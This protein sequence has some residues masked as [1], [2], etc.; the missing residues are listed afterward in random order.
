MGKKH[1]FVTDSTGKSHEVKVDPKHQGRQAREHRAA[2]RE[3]TVLSED[4]RIKYGQ[5]AQQIAKG[6]NR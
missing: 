5:I 2:G 6:K 1:M 4:E 3:V